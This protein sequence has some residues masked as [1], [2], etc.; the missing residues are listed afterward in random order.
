MLW[1]GLSAASPWDA[2]RAESKSLDYLGRGPDAAEGVASFLEKRPPKF[3][4]R[5]T[6]DLPDVGVGDWPAAPPDAT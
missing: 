2:H 6:K 1:S 5:V 4:L 3:P